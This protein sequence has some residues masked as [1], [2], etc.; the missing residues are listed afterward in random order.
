[1]SRLCSFDEFSEVKSRRFSL[2]HADFF[3]FI[4]NTKSAVVRTL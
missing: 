2:I 3:L 1:M 4:L